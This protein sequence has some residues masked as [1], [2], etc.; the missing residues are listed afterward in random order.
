MF[1]QTAWIWMS[2]R[3]EVFILKSTWIHFSEVK[4]LLDMRPDITPM[5]KHVEMLMP[6]LNSHK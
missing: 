5:L 3:P 2:G 6:F 4:I 1:L